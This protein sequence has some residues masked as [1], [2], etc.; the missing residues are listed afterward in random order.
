MFDL[1]KKGIKKLLGTEIATRTTDPNFYG[2]LHFLPNPDT[3]L[4]KMGKSQEVFDAIIQD[5]HVI[6]ELR[7][8][9]ANIITK[10]WRILPGGDKPDDMRAFELAQSVFNRPPV[11]ATESSPGM[12]WTDVFWNMQQA[13]LRGQRIHEVVW[14]LQDGLQVPVSLIDRPNRRFVYGLNNELRLL[15]REQMIE[16]VPVD[17]YK[18][19]VARHMPSFDNPYG[20][21]LLSSCFWPYTFKHNGFRYFTKFCEKYG[22]P[23]AVGKY[24]AGTSQAQ[25]DELADSLARMVE[26]AVA[27]IPDAGS[28]ELIETGTTASTLP[29]E[30]LIQI[31]NAEMS[32]AINSQTL[33]TEING[34]GSRAAAETHRGREQENGAADQKLIESPCNQLLIWMTELNFAGAAAPKF[35]FYDE[36][37]ARKDWVEV[38]EGARQ[39]LDVPVKF[40]H[41]SLQIPEPV[42][43]EAVLPRSVAPTV[44]PPGAGGDSNP[45]DFAAGTEGDPSP[46]TDY[47]NQLSVDAAGSIK[48]LTDVLRNKANN[49]KSL[50]ALRDDL[51]NSYGDMPSDDLVKVMQ[52]SFAAAE[53]AGRFDVSEGR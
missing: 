22:L 31:C 44:L 25:I 4:R 29:Q 46:V 9:R 30:R 28:V 23:W 43:G 50:E 53:L 41:D 37:E 45:S 52:F 5:A 17:N 18:F 34:Q 24:P 36:A 6:G 19:L 12:G 2:T 7:P 13:I 32:K 40:A 16:G 47:A 49:A 3:I 51:L 15:T 20:V 48:Q 42:D 14:G 1:V 33:A 26:D 35:E 21:A 10:N 27:A 38:F 8:M 11:P 39:F